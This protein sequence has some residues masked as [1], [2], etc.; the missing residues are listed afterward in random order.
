[1]NRELIE[2]LN[3][4]SEHTYI[5]AAQLAAQILVHERTVRTRIK[6]LNR[7]LASHGAEVVSKQK[8]GYRLAVHDLDMYTS[9]TSS[10]GEKECQMP[11]SNSDERVNYMLEYLL[12][13][14]SYVKLDFFAEILYVSR[15]TITADIK[16][17]EYIFNRYHIELA[18]RP[19]YGIKAVGSEFDKRICMAN[20]FLK[21]NLVFKKS[22]KIQE[23]QQ[24]LS[25]ILQ[26]V[27]TK[28][29]I[30]ISEIAFQA[31]TMCLYF[32]LRRILQGYHVKMEGVGGE[33]E[34]KDKKGDIDKSMMD[35]AAFIAAEIEMEFSVL[36]SS[37]EV[38]YIAVLLAGT[39]LSDTDLQIN[40]N[41]EI[42]HF[43]DD[44]SMQMILRVRDGFNLDFLDNF[45]FRMSL[46]KHMVPFHI[47]MLYGIPL[48]NP[49]LDNVKKEYPYA[50]NLAAHA[51]TVLNEYYGAR[52][53]EEEVGYFAILFQVALE[54]RENEIQKKNILL[55]CASGMGSSQLFIHRYRQTF[56]KYLNQIREC[57]VLEVADYDY[58]DIDYLFTTVPL[59][60]PVPVP[61][62]VV[63]LFEDQEDFTTVHKLFRHEDTK[64]IERFFVPECFYTDIHL[65]SKEEVIHFLCDAAGEHFDLPENFCDSVMKRENLGQ[66]DFGN[67]A[68]IPHPFSIMTEKSFVL[69]GI[70]K[71][72]I[73]WGHNDVQIVFLI[74][75]SKERDKDIETF[76]RLITNLL[77]DTEKLNQL[78]A[79]PDFLHFMELLKNSGG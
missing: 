24:K 33:A 51:V 63:S 29:S 50:Y 13:H 75:I 22:G 67:L 11:P 6:E 52:I 64:V 41:L 34:G 38:R 46:N 20:H 65:K 58:S 14:S 76:Y 42:T 36:L 19:N 66:T 9:F 28:N 57:T 43:I 4:L 37:E 45:D 26:S 69:V 48:N 15:N 3:L 79:R 1:M 60:V 49:I 7:I 32:G 30:R 59:D 71:E 10:L 5:T 16:K 40:K 77:F 53:P 70:L 78:I 62:F 35:A 74:S 72:P 44:L 18:R 61:V 55:V 68:A 31:L 39:A 56:G 47:R 21:T 23:D 12:D 17:V 25:L 2:I 54:K 8:C 27:L 73:H